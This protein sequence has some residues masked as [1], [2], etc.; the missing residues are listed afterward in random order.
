MGRS[1]GGCI[2]CK[3]RKRKCDETRPACL[4]CQNRPGGCGGYGVRLRWDNGIA[5]RGRFAGASTPAERESSPEKSNTSDD[6]PSTQA[7][8]WASSPSVQAQP[9]SEQ[10]LPELD[11]AEEDR[12]VFQE[13]LRSG[14]QM[15]FSSKKGDWHQASFLQVID[16][17]KAIVAVCVALQLSLDENNFERFHQAYDKAVQLFKD[18]LLESQG[19]LKRGALGAGL[20]LCSV[21]FI[22]TIPWT[23][24]LHCIAD[25]YNFHGDLTELNPH[26]DPYTY[27]F[28]EVLG[29]MDLPNLVLGRQT[30]R[31]QFW[32][33]FRRAQVQ[34]D[35][36]VDG[37]VESVSGVP[38]K[39]LDIIARIGEPGVEEELWIWTGEVGE[40]LQTHLWDAWRY[41]G[42]LVIRRQR[43]KDSTSAPA[44]PDITHT[45]MDSRLPC[46]EV[47]LCRLV[48][49]LDAL[50]VGLER[51]EYQHLLVLNG[52]LFP[53]VSASAEFRLLRQHP[54]WK[55]ALNSMRDQ[56]AKG[57]T[58]KST[59][60]LFGMIDEAWDRGDDI[61]DPEQA[62]A[63]RGVEL[64][65]F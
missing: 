35:H 7:G 2:T 31:L 16:E 21:S 25:L 49:A 29:V 4:A 30:R 15:L 37:G 48:S 45:A 38:R 18:E 11:E 51:V 58:S 63:S 6:V 59:Q 9:S 10:A 28:F 24:I 8:S 33:R 53:Y 27:H 64:A 52:T 55:Q 61:F 17:S 42:I 36:C 41:A 39:L 3:T 22:Q 40:L 47:V 46:T 5:S 19:T 62:A 56:R 65:L 12:R 50:R 57:D 32:R 54:E 34:W 26:V 60:A 13:F 14:I 20:L 23:N 43:G 44:D 1:R